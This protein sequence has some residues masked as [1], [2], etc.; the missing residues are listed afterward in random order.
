M[1]G[2]PDAGNL[3]VRFDEGT[4]ETGGNVPRLRPTLRRLCAVHFTLDA[5]SYNEKSSRT[6]DAHGKDVCS[7]RALHHAVHGMSRNRSHGS[8][9]TSCTKRPLC[10]LAAA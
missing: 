6:E 3:H 9:S 5:S 10:N 7:C 1:I 8:L 2:E 4:L